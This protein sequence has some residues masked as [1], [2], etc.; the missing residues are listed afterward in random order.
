MR[1]RDPDSRPWA[2]TWEGR[3]KRVL[4]TAKGPAVFKTA[5]FASFSSLWSWHS[6]LERRTQAPGSEKTERKA[7]FCSF[8][9]AFLSVSRLPMLSS[10]FLS[11][12]W[13]TGGQG[14]R[15]WTVKTGCGSFPQPGS[16]LFSQPCPHFRPLDTKKRVISGP[17][18]ALWARNLLFSWCQVEAEVRPQWSGGDLSAH[19][20]RSEEG[21]RKAGVR[22][23][24][25]K[26]YR[27]GRVNHWFRPSHLSLSL[28]LAYARACRQV[29]EG[30]GTD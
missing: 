26:A 5:V 30:G 11:R 19:V 17:L 15:E 12:E 29:R 2:K 23:G 14:L 22:A 8:L 1:G 16:V 25:A 4:L 28:P 10:L 9:T 20:E 6:R 13:W 18:A 3:R 24:P 7:N 21:E 27:H